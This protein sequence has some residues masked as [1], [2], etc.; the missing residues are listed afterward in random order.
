VNLQR[1]L[2][3]LDV[4]RGFDM[5]WIIGGDDIARS[6]KNLSSTNVGVQRVCEQF[7]EHVSWVGFHFYDMI[8]PL[9][10]FII[11]ATL[12]FSL[13]RRLEEGQSKKS[14]VGKILWRVA[15]LFGL[16]LI[17][18]GI[19]HADG[20]EHVR[21]FGVL[22][23]QAL[24]YGAAAILFLSLKPRQLV[25]VAIAIL[26]G[27]WALMS[28]FPVPGYGRGDYSE[29]GNLA[30]YVDRLILWPG[31]M[32]EV[33]GDPEGLLSMIPAVA[34]ALLGLFAGLWLKSDRDEQKK[35]LGL[36]GGGM[37]LIALG[38]LWAPWFPVIKKIW[39]SSYVLV[40]GGGSALLLG[41][42]YWLADVRRWKGWTFP[43]VVIG[44]NAIT[45]YLLKEIVDFNH[46]AEYFVG[47]IGKAFPAYQELLMAISVVVAEWLT[48][49]LFYK[50]QLFL[51]V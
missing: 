20:W 40:A 23:R 5:F 44:T 18:N 46:V 14:L 3:S 31:Q 32:Y 30:N 2:V 39:T 17:N 34:T 49:Y 9:F 12:P 26:L 51:R 42:T 48:L 36:I 33:Y 10:L 4:L 37:A 6:I 7:S 15:I 8:F 27:Y 11:G 28:S 47:G 38:C 16:G 41:V 13:G 25:A 21:I 50:K 1:R 45:I 24:G 19:L 35:A 43:F 22:Q 29:W